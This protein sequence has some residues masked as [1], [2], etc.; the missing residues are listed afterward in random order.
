[1]ESL[2]SN[3]HHQPSSSSGGSKINRNKLGYNNII[4]SLL[5]TTTL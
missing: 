4:A 1:L 5:R 2:E 3:N